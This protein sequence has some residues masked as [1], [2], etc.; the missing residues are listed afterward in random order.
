[1][2]PTSTTRRGYALPLVFVFTVLLLSALGVAWRQI[3]A[4]LQIEAVRAGQAQHDQSSL[5]VLA[6]AM[7]LLET[8][9]PAENDVSYSTLLDGS[10]QWYTLT[11]TRHADDATVWSVRVV[12]AAEQSETLMPLTFP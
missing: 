7:R 11:F 1:M 9:L 4:V 10:P 5:L 8:G 2:K 12:K 6:K 3:G